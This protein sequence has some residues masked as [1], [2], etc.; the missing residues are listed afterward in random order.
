LTSLNEL[1]EH[2]NRF[3]GKRDAIGDEVDKKRGKLNILA[4][5]NQNTEL[6]IFLLKEYLNISTGD[7]IKLFEKTVT[8]G[9]QEIFGDEYEF[10]IEVV[11]HQNNNVCNFLLKTDEYE[12]PI[13][14]TQTQGTC[15]KEI[16]SVICR[17]I[18]VCLSKDCHKTI[19]L[20]EPFSGAE[21][22]R[23]DA[24][25]EFLQ[26]VIKDFGIQVILI[27]HNEIYESYADKVVRI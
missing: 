9:L 4:E 3:I 25:A 26:R 15:L 22:E 20:D 13:E 19:I 27:T 2:Y 17:I 10:S 7:V 16:V 8:S 1:K 24:I 14:I 6:A 23:T 11:S 5:E 21:S 18:I 12:E